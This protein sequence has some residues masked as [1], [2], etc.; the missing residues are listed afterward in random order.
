MLQWDFVFSLGY[1]PLHHKQQ[2]INYIIYIHIFN[3]IFQYHSASLLDFGFNGF[4]LFLLLLRTYSAYTLFT[5]ICIFPIFC[6]YSPVQLIPV[7]IP[8][9]PVIS[10]YLCMLSSSFSFS[11]IA[12]KFHAQSFPKSRQSH[13][14]CFVLR[15]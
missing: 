10:V 5:V 11:I 7:H 4:C 15:W 9:K 13:N 6:A 2:K 8:V 14:L 1:L 3:N 12:F